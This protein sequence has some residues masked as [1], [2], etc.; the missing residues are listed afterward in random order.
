M[1]ASGTAALAPGDAAP[2]FSLPAT[3]G[4]TYTLES[5]AGASA[6][7]VVFLAN[8]CPYVASWEDR[9]VAIAREYA[10]RGVRV[11]AVSSND[12]TRFPQDG[13]E[14]MARRV[15]EAGYPFPYLFDED[16][17]VARAFGATR[18]PEVFL[19]DPAQR[20]AYHGAID[21]DWEESAAVEPYLRQALEA[22]LRGAE[23]EPADTHPTGCIIKPRG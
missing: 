19:F 12:V 6:A 21:S 15:V 2:P 18:T 4:R 10:D 9:L 1:T 3:D 11:L 20:L 8:H 7:I 22:V 17:A 13:P 16:G 5:M 14:E 23:P